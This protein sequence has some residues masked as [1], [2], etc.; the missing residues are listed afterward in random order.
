M[1]HCPKQEFQTWNGR[2]DIV[3]ETTS[4][5]GQKSLSQFPQL[6]GIISGDERGR[7]GTIKKEVYSILGFV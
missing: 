4:K 1:M 5:G 6:V 2:V 7:F 3:A